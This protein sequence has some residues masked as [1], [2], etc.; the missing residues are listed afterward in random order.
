MV[1]KMDHLL[2]KR[3]IRNITMRRNVLGIRNHRDNN[4]HFACS[5]C[6]TLLLLFIGITI[7]LEVGIHAKCMNKSYIPGHFWQIIRF[8][9]VQ[10]IALSPNIIVVGTILCVH[11]NYV[12]YVY[13]YT[14]YT[15]TY[16]HICVVRKHV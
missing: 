7:I 9:C 16:I 13:I 4:A 2:D 6:R 15:Y 1:L 3:I 11:C 10:Y 8:Y 14:L 12:L 5:V